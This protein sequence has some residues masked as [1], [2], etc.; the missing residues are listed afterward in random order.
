MSIKKVVEYRYI[1]DHIELENN[2]WM[3]PEELKNQKIKTNLMM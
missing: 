3:L 1:W 2:E